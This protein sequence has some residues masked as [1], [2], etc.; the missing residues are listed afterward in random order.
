[1]KVEDHVRRKERAD[2]ERR[3]A[4]L[5]LRPYFAML[6]YERPGM[7][8]STV[9]S[10]MDATPGAV[11]N[12]FDDGSESTLKADELAAVEKTGTV[13]HRMTHG[14]VGPGWQRTIEAARDAEG[15]DCVVLMEDDLRFSVSW[16]DVLA[17]MYTA[18][19]D[20]V[21]F[22][23]C[24][25]AH[26]EVKGSL[27]ELDGVEAFYVPFNTFQVNLASQEFLKELDLKT[28]SDAAERER[29]GIDYHLFPQAKRLGRKCIVSAR[30]YVAHIGA[31]DSGARKA[32]YAY[33]PFL[34][35]NPVYEVVHGK[36]GWE[37]VPESMEGGGK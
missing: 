4:R 25:R 6:T 32:G 5:R 15:C 8:T 29:T 10:F 36:L 19:G 21:G 24:F 14:G 22:V 2:A 1:M 23:S 13:V 28:A 16:L 20:K 11:L 34:A 3:P 31:R 18:A 35:V 33:Y 30:S 26:S 27:V 12:V 17:R 37:P 9:A 7:L